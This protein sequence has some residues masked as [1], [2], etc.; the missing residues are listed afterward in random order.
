MKTKAAL[1]REA[2]HSEA[3]HGGAGQGEAEHR[4]AEHRGPEHRGAEHRGAERKQAEYRQARAPG[5]RCLVVIRL[6]AVVLLAL[7]AAACATSAK[8][9]GGGTSSG[10]AGSSAPASTAPASPTTSASPVSC[11]GGWITGPLTVAHQIAVPPVPVAESIRTGSHPDCR[12]DRLVIDFSGPTPGYRARFVTQVVQDASGKPITMPGTRFL[13]I[14]FSPAQGH[15]ASGASTLPAAVQ[16]TGYP[17]LRGYAVSGD[18]EGYLSI[19]LGLAGG[20]RYR[21]G[22]LPG[23]VYVDVSW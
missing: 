15:T 14:T 23:R 18:F 16:T 6:G 17:M 5:A 9:G 12:F 20:V 22:E 4:A 21:V 3:E 11:P 1:H 2:L 19:A 13:V 8:P 7:G 10:P